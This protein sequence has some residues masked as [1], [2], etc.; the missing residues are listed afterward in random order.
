MTNVGNIDGFLVS[1]PF[2]FALHSSASNL[3]QIPLHLPP[4]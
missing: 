4:P 3:E 1:F 2:S